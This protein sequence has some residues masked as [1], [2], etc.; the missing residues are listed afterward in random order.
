MNNYYSNNPRYYNN[1]YNNRQK[2]CYSNIG[3]SN[4][5]SQKRDYGKPYQKSSAPGSTE[6]IRNLFDCD[7]STSSLLSLP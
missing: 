2:S 3:Y 4:C 7:M 6:G 5:L 1:Y